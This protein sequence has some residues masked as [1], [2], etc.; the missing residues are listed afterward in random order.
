MAEF[1]NETPNRPKLKERMLKQCLSSAGL[2]FGIER[3]SDP[4]CP[5]AYPHSLKEHDAKST[6][7]CPACKRG[8]REKFAQ[9]RS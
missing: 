7:L 2:I 6:E 1:N 3:C 4:T 8:F 5:R 9:E